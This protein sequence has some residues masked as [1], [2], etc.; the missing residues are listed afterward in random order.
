M[1]LIFVNSIINESIRVP[2][3]RRNKA[4][5]LN[6]RNVDVSGCL[7]LN[8]EILLVVNLLHFFVFHFI[9]VGAGEV[10]VAVVGA[11]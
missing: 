1:K 4:H 10:D 9:V 7:V 8:V 2:T 11:G 3:L 5:T 6:R